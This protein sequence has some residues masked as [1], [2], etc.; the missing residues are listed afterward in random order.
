MSGSAF[1]VTARETALS[2]KAYIKKTKARKTPVKQAQRLRAKGTSTGIRITP[3]T[4]KEAQQRLS[5]LG[6]WIGAVSGKWNESSKFGLVA[7]QKVEGRPRTGRLLPSD[8]LALR[9]AQRP[10]PRDSKSAHIEVDLRRQVL[11]IVEADGI[12][13]KI[14][15]VSTASGKRFEIDGEVDIAVT[16]V[17]KF[18]VYRKLDGWRESPLGL[19][20]YPNYI[21]GGIAIHG[22]PSVPAVPASHGCIRIPMFAAK[23]FSDMT[24]IGTPVLVYNDSAA[25]SAGSSARH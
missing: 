13:S 10:R 25:A 3:A 21:V 18:Q 11:F 20:Y 2:K 4:I 17:G 12:V 22:N 15:P 16:P 5:D 19:L 24:P 23:R 7:F 1:T 6:Y 9:T 8:L 14:L